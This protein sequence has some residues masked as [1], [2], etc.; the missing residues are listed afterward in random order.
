MLSLKAEPSLPGCGPVEEVESV[1]GAKT[2]LGTMSWQ[3][4]CK[5]DD[6]ATATLDQ[7]SEELEIHLESRS[8]GHDSLLI[9][10]VRGLAMQ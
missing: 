4:D 6:R 5:P 8:G 7:P 1:A 9:M 2:T 10:L 3:S